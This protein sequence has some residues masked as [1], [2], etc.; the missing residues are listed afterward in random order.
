MR[1]Q[2]FALPLVERAPIPMSLHGT[3]RSPQLPA[4]VGFVRERAGC[5]QER[6]ALGE[7]GG[8][9]QFPKIPD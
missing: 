2:P 8:V 7:P 5:A 1:A 3:V 6:N 4:M 9:G